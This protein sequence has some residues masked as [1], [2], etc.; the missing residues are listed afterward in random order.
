MVARPTSRGFLN[1]I[2]CGIDGSLDSGALAALAASIAAIS[3]AKLRLVHVAPIHKR[4]R[5]ARTLQ[6]SLSAR[7]TQET[8]RGAAGAGASI[9]HRVLT[10]RP[11]RK[12]V[13]YSN[14]HGADLLIVGQR[15]HGAVQ[16]A[17]LGSVSASCVRRA[18]CSVLVS[19]SDS[20]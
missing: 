13:A 7:E 5:A 4:R 17:L 19:R 10:G 18:R 1:R 16:R 9:D 14:R 8:F 6:Q 3:G 20:K 11:E 2:V 15:T 12:L